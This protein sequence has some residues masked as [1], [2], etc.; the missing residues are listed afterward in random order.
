[1]S[2]VDGSSG[3]VEKIEI[4]WTSRDDSFIVLPVVIFFLIACLWMLLRY[5]V[6]A[7]TIGGLVFV[8]TA[9]VAKLQQTV[10]PEIYLTTI[11]PEDVRFCRIDREGVS[12]C[13]RKINVVCFKT[14]PPSW[15][16]GEHG[17]PQLKCILKTGQE[18][19]ID[20]RFIWD[21]N[22]DAFYDA[23]ELLWGSCYAERGRFDRRSDDS[24]D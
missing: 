11:T 7:M 9:G 18:I 2:I 15:Y 23:I 5:G 4:R 20:V 22:R 16:H 17:K 8:A 19:K 3:K 12:L 1:M 10:W 13:L 21:G 6:G 24:R 14:E